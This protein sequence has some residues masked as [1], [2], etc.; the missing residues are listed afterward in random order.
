MELEERVRA[1]EE[2]LKQ[3]EE[4]KILVDSALQ[5]ANVPVYSW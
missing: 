5:K 3:L 4:W 2:R 1:L